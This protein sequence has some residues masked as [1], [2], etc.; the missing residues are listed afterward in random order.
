MMLAEI[1]LLALLSAGSVG[2]H[3]VSTLHGTC[4]WGEAHIGLDSMPW[5]LPGAL[6]PNGGWQTVLGG[7]G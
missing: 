6:L 3:S 7:E 4:R 1:E 5:I 2:C